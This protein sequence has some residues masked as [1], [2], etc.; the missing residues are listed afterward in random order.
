MPTSQNDKQIRERMQKLA[1]QIDELRYRYHVLDDPAVT[2]QVYDSLTQ[3]L[4]ELERKY[5]KFKPKN[6]PTERIGGVALDKFSKVEHKSRM[7][8]LNDAF[9]VEDVVAWEE[10]VKKN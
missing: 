9:S 4:L 1:A 3:E 7:L 10:R 2:D 6:S 5:P 8:S